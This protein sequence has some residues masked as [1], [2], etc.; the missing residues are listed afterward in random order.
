MGADFGDS[1]ADAV[2]HGHGRGVVEEVLDG[3]VGIAVGGDEV[4][5]DVVRGDV[6]QELGYPRGGCGGRAA[7]AEARAD[8]FESMR[9][10]GV[11]L[12]IGLEARDAAPEVDVGLVPDL[13][14]PLGD[15]VDAVAVDH[16]L[17]E[18]AD[19]GVPVIP[20]ARRGD[21]GVV[22]E[23]VEGV[24]VEGHLRGHEA[25]LDKRADALGEHA[26][27]D[28]VGLGEVVD[29]VA[30][31]VA[32]ED[33]DVVVE[34]A[35]EADPAEIGDG[36][37]GA[38][39]AAPGLAEGEDGVAGA[40]H[41]LPEMREGRGGAG[42]VDGDGFGLAD[43]GGDE[44]GRKRGREKAGGDGHRGKDACELHSAGSPAGLDSAAG[45]CVVVGGDGRGS[46]ESGSHFLPHY[47]RIPE[48]RS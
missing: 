22:P 17:G 1:G 21:V 16:V 9:G 6:S 41:L 23:D 30:V 5:G 2:V 46:A 25:E 4:D 45:A 14:V 37:D 31:L 18:G 24:R 15:F 44:L 20:A 34:D 40:E 28:F 3:V 43:G 38:E 12:L 48:D 19:E 47:L 7:D 36:F 32:G 33:S 29:G 39:V 42:G 11:E 10:V 27:V 35:V 8:A 13:E 26:V